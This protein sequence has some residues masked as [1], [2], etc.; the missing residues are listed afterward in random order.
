[1]S[2]HNSSVHIDHQP[3]RTPNQKKPNNCVLGR[4]QNPSPE[5]RTGWA[6][7][8]ARR[9]SPVG[10]RRGSEGVGLWQGSHVAMLNLYPWSSYLCLSSAFITGVGSVGKLTF[11]LPSAVRCQSAKEFCCHILSILGIFFPVLILSRSCACCLNLWSFLCNFCIVS[12]HHCCLELIYHRWLF[13]SFFPL[14][15]KESLLL[16]GEMWYRCP[17]W[18]WTLHSLY[19]FYSHGPDVGLCVLCQLQ[20]VSLDEG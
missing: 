16:G 19:I 7:P 3:F 12:R 4:P 11:P 10:C 20:E 14:I 15:F 13:S 8:G 5:H 9:P 6:Q 2:G 18:G 17:I 1:M